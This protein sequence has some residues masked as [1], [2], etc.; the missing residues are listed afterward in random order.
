MK[1]KFRDVSSGIVEA[2]AIIEM[3]PGIFINEVTILKKDG[4][5]I[6]ELPQK[7]FR[8]KD[9]RMHYL[10]IL[11]FESENRETLWKMEVKEEYLNWRKTNK[12]VLVYES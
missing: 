8:G 12:K 4:E 5:I 6:V 2:R 9:D 1:I 11:T 10:N 7:S 3:V